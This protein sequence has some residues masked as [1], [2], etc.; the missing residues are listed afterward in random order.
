MYEKRRDWEK[1]IAVNQR[2]IDKLTDA[3][4]RKNRRIEVAKLA[5][6]K[7]KKASVSIEL[8]QKVLADDA[9]NMEALGELEKLYERE[10]AWS[11][12]GAVLER[13]V[14]ASDDATRK[15]AIYVKLGILFTEKVHNAAQATAAWQAL[16]ALEP[17]NRRAQDALKKLYLQSK[18]WDALEAFYAAQNKWDELVRVLERQAETEDE[19]GRVG[20]WNK[21]GELYRDRLNKADRAQKAYE[22]ALS[23]DGREPAGGAG[24]DPALREGQGR[25]APRPRCCS[26]SSDTRR[27][28]AERH[29]AHAA[30]RRPARPGRGRQARRAARSRCRPS[31]RRP[32][33]SGRS[34]RRAGWP[35]RA[36]AG[37]S[38]SR[39][40]R[41]RCRAPRRGRGGACSRCWRRWPPRTSASSANPELAIARNQ[42]ILELR[43]QGPGR[44]GGARAP[45]HR[46]RALRGPARHLRQEAGAGQEQGRGARDPLQAGRPLRGADQAARQG[47][48][49]LSARS[50]SRIRQQLPALRRSIASTSSSVAGRTWRRRSTQ[51]IDLSTDMAAVAELKFRRGAVQEQHLE[52]G[53]GA[54]ASYREA[55]ALE[56][57]HDGARD[58]AAGVSVQQ[59]RRA[60]ARG[61]RRCWSR[62][63]RRTT[64]SPRL[65]EV[66]RIKLAHEKKTDKRVDLLLRIG[67]L[68]GQ[69]G[70]TDQAWEAYTRAF[71]E[72]P[73]SAAAREA[74]ENLANI[75]DNWQ[76]L[77]ALYEKALSAKGKEKLPSALER[78]L[79]LVVAVAYDEKL[80][81]VGERGRVLP[82]RAEHPARGRLGAGGAGAALHPHR[83]LE[84]SG[85]HAAEEGAAGHRR[86]RARGDPDPHRHASGKRC[87][88]T[89]S[90][91]SSPGTSCCR[92]TRATCRRCARSIA[93]TWRAASS[94]SWPTTCSGS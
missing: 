12:L 31:P 25:Q 82:A 35:A 40:T 74:L 69:L 45:L 11:E 44:G 29:A 15:S 39:P 72:S 49:A 4:E 36:A 2:E 51:E 76:P 5:S 92:T 89:P 78:E 61:R 67:K 43:A 7:M 34:R 33:T 37:P 68:E 10:K 58:R 83:A 93:C 20:L 65:V 3:G 55:L 77:V 73:A 46:D 79:L 22:K 38:W 63:T 8:W 52:D 81:T 53:A 60:A 13:Q 18:D 26:S 24:A 9:D 48:R 84:R 50:S 42:K 88:A 47:D 16:L 86:R 32:P 57:S 75:L 90:R 6:E 1:L 19:A 62:S 94:A 59:R 70:N 14:A 21:I 54:V 66:Q 30:A 41:R 71:A 23:F 56:P 85:R 80:G 87:W 91:R 17:E 27:D 64:I 28:P